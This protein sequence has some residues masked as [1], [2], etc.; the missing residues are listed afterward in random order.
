MRHWPSHDIQVNEIT[1]HYA[2]T[3]GD[4]PPFLLAHGLTDYG[5]CW[6]P[7]AQALERDYDLVMPDARGHGLSS[8]PETGYDYATL[9]ADLLAL[10]AALGLER[11][12]LM[13][14]SMGAA[15]VAQVAAVRPDLP[16]AVILED[17]PWRET[18]PVGGE[19]R[20]EQAE[21]LAERIAEERLH[22]VDQ[23]VEVQR[24]QQPAWSDTELIHWAESKRQVSPNAAKIITAKTAPWQETL[25]R[26]HCPLLLLHADPTMGAIITE[27]I[28]AE[29]RSLWQK[30][31]DVL[32]PDAGH[33]IHREQ[34]QAVM[35]A[36][37]TFI[38]G[39][40]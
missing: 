10:I 20:R 2:R 15:T 38:E 36:T 12:L 3:G 21:T 6:T 25:A 19:A 31:Q 7:V 14:H 16:R 18:L 9:A 22:S 39:V 40:E 32:I 29:A 35:R 28:A 13:G 4:K 11:P 27:K 1:V 34:F 17:A 23:L 5:L 24:L 30:G 37:T 33:C 26:I 8:A